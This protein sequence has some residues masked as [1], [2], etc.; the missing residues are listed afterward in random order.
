VIGLV[1]SSSFAS[2]HWSVVVSVGAGLL[3]AGTLPLAFVLLIRRPRF[4]PAIG[5]LSDVFSSL[6]PE[7]TY[8]EIARTIANAIERNEQEMTKNIRSLRSGAVLIIAGLLLVAISLIYS[9]YN[10]GAPPQSPPTAHHL[11]LTQV[12]G[13]AT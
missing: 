4:D 8:H 9:H 12:V 1:F 11:P 6:P 5:T 13:F 10:T 2:A 3:G 7:T